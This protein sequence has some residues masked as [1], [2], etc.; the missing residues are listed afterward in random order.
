[1]PSIKKY[2]RRIGSHFLQTT[3]IIL[4]QIIRDVHLSRGYNRFYYT[5]FGLLAAEPYI[6]AKANIL[7]PYF[8]DYVCGHS[9]L[10]IGSANGYFSL[11]AGLSG[12]RE[13]LGVERNQGLLKQADKVRRH[14][15]LT[16]IQFE[17]CSIYDLNQTHQ[18]DVL[19]AL[20]IIHWFPHSQRPGFS[21]FEGIFTY[22]DSLIGKCAF[23]EYI[24]PQDPT[25]IQDP[26]LAKMNSLNRSSFDR[27][28]FVQCLQERFRVVKH[29]GDPRPTRSIYL[30]A[31]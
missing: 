20:A 1:M 31:R 14:I 9:V 11:L 7:L 6:Q 29:L 16:Q 23:V 8:R 2:F 3:P 13:V 22:L 24:A 4:Q 21:T 17:N 10:D 18:R 30:A 26:E 19:L 12:A 28:I 5:K 15:G 27:E 25:F